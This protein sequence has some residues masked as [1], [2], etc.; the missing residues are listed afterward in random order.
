MSAGGR[1]PIR[2]RVVIADDAADFRFLLRMVLDGDDRFDVVGEAGDG[3]EAVRITSEH[4]PHVVL[5]DL[6]MPVMDGLQAIPEIHR[7]SPETHIVVL[8]G[9]EEAHM[10]SRALSLK[11]AAYIEK[12]HA[13]SVV[14]DTLIDVC[15]SP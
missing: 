15:L 14:A 7:L 13:H 6:A 2:L 9:F 1:D 4:Q 11:A 12:G 5:L 3:R 10:G 8:S